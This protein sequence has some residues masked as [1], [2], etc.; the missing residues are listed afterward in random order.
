MS[1]A[2]RQTREVATA[3]LPPLPP[4]TAD[5]A[6]RPAAAS[7]A[8][9]DRA[10]APPRPAPRPD[11]SSPARPASADITRETPLDEAA[12]RLAADLRAIPGIERFGS[13]RLGELDRSGPRPLRTVWRIAREQLDERWGQLTIGEMLDRYGGGRS[14]GTGASA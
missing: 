10:V 4:V 11:A 5:P 6:T 3:P 9:T 7:V 1:E 13:V 8:A 2:S 14:G 12:S